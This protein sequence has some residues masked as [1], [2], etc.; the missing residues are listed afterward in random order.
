[1]HGINLNRIEQRAWRSYHQDGLMDIAFGAMLLVVFAGSAADQF[2]WVGIPLLLVVGPAL[3]LAKRLVTA[4]RLGSVKFG[5]ARKARKRRVVLV[6]ALLVA[7]TMLVPVVLG[8]DDWLRAHFAFMSV[9]LG[10]WVFAAFAAI[11]FWLQLTRMY[12]VGMLF[13]GAFTLAE[14]LD[15]PLPFLVAGAAVAIS[16]TVQL[17]RFLRRYP[18]PVS[19]DD[20][21]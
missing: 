3:A 10:V 17:V 13:G 15:S 8:G 6:I 19:G 16:G 5:E 14:L 7:A 4:P 9:A 1:M 2:H 18:R 20:T 12:V 21:R 11:A